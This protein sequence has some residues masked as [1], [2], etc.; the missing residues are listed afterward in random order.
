MH[1]PTTSHLKAAYHILHLKK[2][3]GQGLLHGRWRDLRVEAFIDVDWTGSVDIR[4]TPQAIAPL[5]G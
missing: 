4:G 1:A 3:P 5:L 2:S